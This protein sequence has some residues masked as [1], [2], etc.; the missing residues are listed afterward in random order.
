MRVLALVVTIVVGTAAFAQTG[1]QEYRSRCSACH[2]AD[3]NG[4]ERGPAIVSRL[5]ARNDQQ[6]IDL[7]HRG[8]PGAGM[9][10]YELPPE[11]MSNLVAFSSKPAGS[12]GSRP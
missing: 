9:P 6:L 11:Q 10:G 7:I 12:K 1:E 5:Q 2:G 8:L 4:G 3:G